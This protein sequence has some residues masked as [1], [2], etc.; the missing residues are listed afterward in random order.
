MIS[1][2]PL[3]IRFD[4]VDG[5]IRVYDGT[6]YL[7]LFGPEI[8]DSIYNRIRCLTTQKSGITYLFSRNYARIKI[9]SSDF[10]PLEKTQTLH[11]VVIHI[12]KD[13]NNYYYNIFL[14]ICLY[15]LAKK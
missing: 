3:H 5:L 15:Q 2:K 14:Q 12:N 8:Y 11:N 1:A 4:N 10:L 7:V 6:R 13:E 9:D